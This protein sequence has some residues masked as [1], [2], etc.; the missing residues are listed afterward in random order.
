MTDLKDVIRDKLRL[1]LAKPIT[2]EG[3]VVYVLSLIRKILEVEKGKNDRK[4]QKLKFYCDWALHTEIDRGTRVFQEEF[5]RFDKGD[6]D[7]IRDI[8]THQ[9][10]EPEFLAFLDENNISTETYRIIDNKHQF[11]KLLAKIYADSMLTV[12]ITKTIRIKANEGIF[13]REG[14]L[15]KV[16]IGFHAEWAS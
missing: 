1:E 11:R 13:S 7:A 9:F 8:I 3:Q 5:E 15:I 12:T 2:E 4:Y 10:F 6:Q 16:E 14:D